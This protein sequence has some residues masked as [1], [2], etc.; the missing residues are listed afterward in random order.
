LSSFHF[1]FFLSSFFFLLFSLYQLFF[2]LSYNHVWEDANVPMFL[3]GQHVVKFWK[4]MILSKVLK[5]KDK[6]EVVFQV[7]WHTIQVHWIRRKCGWICIM[8]KG[9]FND[10]WNGGL[11]KG[12]I[13]HNYFWTYYNKFGK[14][15]KSLLFKKFKHK[16]CTFT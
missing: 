4:K 10:D 7:L 12:N 14:N 6:R 8:H 1:K 5:V 11:W 16:Y 3:F 2:V 15:N 9:G 13:I